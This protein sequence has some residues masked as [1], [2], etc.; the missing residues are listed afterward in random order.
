[1]LQCAILNG[2]AFRGFVGFDDCCKRRYWVRAEVETLSLI[3]EIIGVFLLK[4]R[5]ERRASSCEEH[6]R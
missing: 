6:G 4:R 1:M 3:S 2:P 5:L